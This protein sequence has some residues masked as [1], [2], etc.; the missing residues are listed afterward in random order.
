MLV[1]VAQKLYSTAFV[2]EKT[3][4]GQ[5]NANLTVQSNRKKNTEL[6]FIF[7]DG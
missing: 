2:K 4:H 7:K 6:T 3:T 1:F 5:S